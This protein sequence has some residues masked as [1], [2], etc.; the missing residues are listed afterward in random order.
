M[1]I[2]N[3][4]FQLDPTVSVFYMQGAISTWKMIFSVVLLPFVGLVSVPDMYVT[5]GKFESLGPALSLIFSNTALFWLYALL[6]VSNGLHAFVGMAIIKEESAMQR[7]IVMML[8][9]PVVWIF[10]MLYQAEGHEEFSWKHLAG[11]TILTIGTF[12]Y[13]RADRESELMSQHQ[14]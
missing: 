8:I 1:L 2:E 10:F 7:Q 5:G 14:A 12:W 3:R 11:L 9:I 6:M 4:I 13:I